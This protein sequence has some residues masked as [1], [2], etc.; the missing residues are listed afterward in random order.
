MEHRDG[1][2]DGD[3]VTI[4]WQRPATVTASHLRPT[5]RRAPDAGW[6]GGFHKWGTPLWKILFMGKILN[7]KI[8]EW[9]TINLWMGYPKHDRFIMEN[10]KIGVLGV[11]PWLV[12]NLHV[13]PV[14]PIDSENARENANTPTFLQ[15][16]SAKFLGI[17]TLGKPCDCAPKKHQLLVLTGPWFIIRRHIYQ[18]RGTTSYVTVVLDSPPSSL[19]IYDISHKISIDLSQTITSQSVTIWLCNIAMVKPWP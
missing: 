15:Q 4:V 16:Y 12:G 2:Q 14:V 9:G 13:D 5:P 17:L 7:P 19:Y 1:N 8:C 10:P 3:G 18:R 6:C 11:A